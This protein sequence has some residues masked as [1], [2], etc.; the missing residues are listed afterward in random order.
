MVM[1]KSG[2]LFIVY[3]SETELLEDSF[4]RKIPIL[5]EYTIGICL[6]S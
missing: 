2:D 4:F 6:R 1:N 5:S 3:G